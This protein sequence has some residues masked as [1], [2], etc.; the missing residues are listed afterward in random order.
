MP[1][2]AASWDERLSEVARHLGEIGEAAEFRS[3]ALALNETLGAPEAGRLRGTG[4][5][6]GTNHVKWMVASVV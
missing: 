5:G 1:G 4:S 6:G 3:S 2:S